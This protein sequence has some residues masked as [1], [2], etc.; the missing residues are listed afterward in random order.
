MKNIFKHLMTVVVAAV[1]M[2]TL[3]SY[4]TTNYQNP[5]FVEI[6]QMAAE[7]ADS[8]CPVDL[9]NG[10][11]MQHVYLSHNNMVYD[12]TAPSP[13][14]NDLIACMKMDEEG[15]IDAYITSMINDDEV[16]YFFMLCAESGYGM[17]FRY[18]CPEDNTYTLIELSAQRLSEFI[19]SEFTHAELNE[20]T[21]NLF[22]KYLE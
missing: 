10:M 3:S 16:I 22:L 17:E 11:T 15:T 21:N 9:G 14:V 6:L 1:T 4:K 8:G 20:I 5:E 2:L 7:G 19:H 13:I 18:R 12:Y